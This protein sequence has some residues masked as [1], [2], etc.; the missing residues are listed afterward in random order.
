MMDKEGVV[1]VNVD[2]SLWIP[3]FCLPVC[4]PKTAAKLAL[5]QHAGTTSLLQCI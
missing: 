2:L 3:K 1:L 4:S 5:G